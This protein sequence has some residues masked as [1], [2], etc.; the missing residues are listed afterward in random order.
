LIGGTVNK[1]QELE[2]LIKLGVGGIQ[3]DF[4]HLLKEVAL[5]NGKRIE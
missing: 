2:C 5:R 3:T 4:P 1:K